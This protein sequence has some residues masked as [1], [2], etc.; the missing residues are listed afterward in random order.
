MMQSCFVYIFKYCFYA[1]L[2]S[3]IIT[4]KN[5]SVDDVCEMCRISNGMLFK[6]LSLYLRQNQYI[7]HKVITACNGNRTLL[8]FVPYDVAYRYWHTFCNSSIPFNVFLKVV[9]FLSQRKEILPS[10]YAFVLNENDVARLSLQNNGCRIKQLTKEQQ[11]NLELVQI[12]TLQNGNALMYACD[13]LRDNFD[14]VIPCVS[15]FPWALEHCSTRCRSSVEVV[16]AAI[17]SAHWV[18]RYSLQC[19]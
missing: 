17:S 8:R 2:Q 13:E 11:S 7:I 1:D 14:I 12:A 3:F 5:H 6:Y 16:S 10:K 18:K 9:F 4:R 15:K 19:A